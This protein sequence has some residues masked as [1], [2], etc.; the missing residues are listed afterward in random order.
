MAEHVH[1]MI[2]LGNLLYEGRVG[3]ERK[4]ARARELYERAIDMAEHVN[5]MTILGNL[6]YEGGVGVKHNERGSCIKRRWM[7]LSTSMR[8]SKSGPCC[9]KARKEW[10]STPFDRGIC[11]KGRSRRLMTSVRCTISRTCSLRARKE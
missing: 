4:A 9:N 2:I 6:L 11:E 7:G 5:A 8:S 10:G 3:V 1:A